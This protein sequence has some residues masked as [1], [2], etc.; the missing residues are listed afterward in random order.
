MTLNQP[1]LGP[2][3]DATH[4]GFP[5]ATATAH[6]LDEIAL[7]GLRPGEDEPERRPLPEAGDCRN[8]QERQ[9]AS[10]LTYLRGTK[11]DSYSEEN[12][13]DMTEINSYLLIV[14]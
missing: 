14:C 10:Y 7:Y 2:D 3:G 4:P 9:C 6:L 1:H 11:P 5:G 8:A 13:F 12:Y